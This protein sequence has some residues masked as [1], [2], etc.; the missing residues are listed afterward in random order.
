MRRVCLL[1]KPLGVARD[2]EGQSVFCIPMSGLRTLEF[3]MCSTMADPLVCCFF[4]GLLSSAELAL[5]FFSDI[6]GASEA[7][8]IV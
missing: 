5:R 1:E 4:L 7:G 6:M 2:Y 8:G 3:G